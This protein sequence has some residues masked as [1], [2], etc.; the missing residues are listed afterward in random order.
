MKLKS[1]VEKALIHSPPLYRAASRL[2][3]KVNSDFRTLSPGAPGAIRAAFELR[4]RDPDC[5]FEGDYFEFGVFRGGTFLSA[6]QTVEALALD[7]VRLYG[8]DSFEGL[9]PAE[10]IDAT[11]PRFFEGQFSC[12]RPEVEANLESNGM[13]M[14]RVVLIEGFFS[15]SLTEELRSAHV[16]KPVAVALLDCDYYSSTMEALDWLAPYMRAG[17]VL[18]FDDWSSYGDN[19]DLGQPKAFEDWLAKNTHLKSEQLD[20]FE[21]HGRGFILRAA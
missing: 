11:D 4:Q 8:F 10:G 12:S 7:H 18:L 13:D 6:G 14:D 9:P 19:T 20:D 5:A 1:L 2:Y 3:H 21:A 16:F 17:S 15:D